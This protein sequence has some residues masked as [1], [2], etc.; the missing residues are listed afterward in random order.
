[1][2]PTAPLRR[3]IAAAAPCR[4]RRAMR[5]GCLRYCRHRARDRGRARG[6]RPCS[7]RARSRSRAPS[8]AALSPCCDAPRVAPKAVPPAWSR[9]RRRS[10]DVRWLRIARPH[11][12]PR[13]D[14]RRDEY[15]NAYP[16]RRTAR[17]R[18]AD[19]RRPPSPAIASGP[20]SSHKRAAAA[21][22]GRPRWSR[23]R[24]SC[25]AAAD[26]AKRPTTPRRQK[27]TRIRKR[28]RE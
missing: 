3:A 19:R 6:S 24:G 28:R 7:A 1:M 26:R 4:N 16:H 10:E 14:R 12:A 11:A 22:P 27:P 23:N 21:L 9:S 25:R 8:G 15:E 17:R 5:R 18:S 20:R 2:P 13:E